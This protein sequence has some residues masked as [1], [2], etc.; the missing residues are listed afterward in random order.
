VLPIEQPLLLVAEKPP[1]S[2]FATRHLQ[3]ALPYEHRD[4]A[5]NPAQTAS[6]L[7]CRIDPG[8]IPNYSDLVDP[9][10]GL[11]LVVYGEESAKLLTKNGLRDGPVRYCSE[12]WARRAGSSMASTRRIASSRACRISATT[13]AGAGTPGAL[14]EGGASDRSCPVTI[15][16]LRR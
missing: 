11:K 1:A 12:T 14:G 15:A 5:A 4:R 9:N 10:R 6:D 7:A 8:V 13:E 3:F 16:A 2:G